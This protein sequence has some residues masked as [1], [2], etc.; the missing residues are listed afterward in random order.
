MSARAPQPHG[1]GFGCLTTSLALCHRSLP[2]PLQAASLAAP[3]GK[4]VL[5]GC[6]K[7]AA[8][9]DGLL[10][11]TAAAYVASADL[12]ADEALAADKVWEAACGADSPLLAPSTAAKLAPEDAGA[13][14]EAA[15]VL[16]T[17]VGPSLSASLPRGLLGRNWMPLH[18]RCLPRGAHRLQLRGSSCLPGFEQTQLGS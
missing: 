13:A 2:T 3:L 5:E 16:L 14:A 6:A 10:A 4:L 15:E 7:A 17:Q 12:A 18:A 8:R 11:L 9:L 1:A